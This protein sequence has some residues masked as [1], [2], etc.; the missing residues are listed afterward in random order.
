MNRKRLYYSAGITAAIVTL[1]VVTSRYVRE[2][3]LIL[4]A[5]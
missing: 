4:D 5:N 3:R 1:M 2:S